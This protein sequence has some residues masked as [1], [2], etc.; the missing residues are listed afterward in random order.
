LEK[1]LT[2]LPVD[3]GINVPSHLIAG[4]AAASDAFMA[5]SKLVHPMNRDLSTLLDLTKISTISPYSFHNISARNTSVKRCIKGLFDE[6]NTLTWQSC[7]LFEHSAAV[8]VLQY[9]TIRL[10]EVRPELGKQVSVAPSAAQILAFQR[11]TA[12]QAKQL[13]VARIAEF[14][15]KE[16]E[17]WENADQCEM[18]LQAFLRKLSGDIEA[19]SPGPSTPGASV[20][21]GSSQSTVCDTMEIDSDAE[22]ESE[23]LFMMGAPPGET[24]PIMPYRAFP[25]PPGEYHELD[26]SRLSTSSI[27]QR[28]HRRQHRTQHDRPWTPYL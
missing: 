7:T 6:F 20:G 17:G 1:L 8:K 19:T 26:G 4:Q 27:V 13:S 12:K 10:K 24:L 2:S 21:F 9:L 16:I 25:Q 11:V 18:E 3:D 5:T 23:E 28:F 15:K 14:F 22:G